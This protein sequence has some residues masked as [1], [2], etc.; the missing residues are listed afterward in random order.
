MKLDADKGAAA[1]KV[2]DKEIKKAGGE[3]PGGRG[4][5]AAEKKPA[6]GDAKPEAKPAPAEKKAG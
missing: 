2:I 5:V 6:E 3:A 4:E 1:R